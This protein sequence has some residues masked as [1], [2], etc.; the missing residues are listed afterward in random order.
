LDLEEPDHVLW[1]IWGLQ[2]LLIVQMF[3]TEKVDLINEVLTEAIDVFGD[4]SLGSEVYL[5]GEI[6]DHLITWILDHLYDLLLF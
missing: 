5:V 4:I 3:F 2:V 1:R 6:P